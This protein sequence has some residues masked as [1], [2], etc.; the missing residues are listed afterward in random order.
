MKIMVKIL[1]NLYKEDLEI[2]NTDVGGDTQITYL[3]TDI[4]NQEYWTPVVPN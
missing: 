2:S 3:P 1:K 4:Y